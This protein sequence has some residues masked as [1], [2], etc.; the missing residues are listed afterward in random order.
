MSYRMQNVLSLLAVA[1]VLLLNAAL[2]ADS[3]IAG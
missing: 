3:P 1:M 2:G